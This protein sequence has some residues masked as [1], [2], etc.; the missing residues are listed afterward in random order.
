MA[1]ML[2]RL[3]LRH[4]QAVATNRVWLQ[5]KRAVRAVV[6]LFNLHT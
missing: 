6:Y 1:W 3:F 4:K 5:F 2:A